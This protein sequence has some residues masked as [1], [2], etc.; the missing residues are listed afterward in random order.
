MYRD[1]RITNVY[2]GTTQLQVVAAI[3]HVATGTYLQRI[4]EDRGYAVIPEL[5]PLKRSL[6]RMTQMYEKLV[7]IVTS[8]KDEEYF[9]FHARRLVESAGHVIMGYLYYRMPIKSSIISSFCEVYIHYGQ[10]EVIK[11]YNFVTK[12]RINIGYYKPVIST[13]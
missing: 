2:E 5:E 6:S 4:K 13:E 9:D 11:N 10:V 12:S 8:K 1:A 3:R 7:G